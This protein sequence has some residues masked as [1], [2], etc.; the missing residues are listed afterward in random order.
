MEA[1]TVDTAQWCKIVVERW[2]M[3][4]GKYGF[5]PESTGSLINSFEYFADF[6]D[7]E[8]GGDKKKVFFTFLFYGYYWDAGVGNGYYH[9]NGGDLESLSDWAEKNGEGHRKKHRWFN[10]VFW[11]EVLKLRSMLARQY[12]DEAVKEMVQ[13]IERMKI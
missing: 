8:A 1:F 12:G 11:S 5:G 13:G 10:D 3:K 7:N 9:R 4:M 2:I 6:V